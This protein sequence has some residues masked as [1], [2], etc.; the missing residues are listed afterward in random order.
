MGFNIILHVGCQPIYDRQD[1][2]HNQD[3]KKKYGEHHLL[4][5][6][7]SGHLLVEYLLNS[8]HLLFPLS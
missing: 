4:V 6:K 8:A 3:W 1:D 7:Y 2:H 5:L